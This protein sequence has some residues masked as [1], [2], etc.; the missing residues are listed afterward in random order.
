[1][2]ITINGATNTISSTGTVTLPTVAGVTSLGNTALGDAEASDTHAIKGATTLL[3]N[4]ASA[5]LTVTQTG[6]GNAFVVE[7][8]AS[9]DSTPFVIDSAG[10]VGI[11]LTTI[12]TAKALVATSTSSTSQNEYGV[13]AYN[14][15]SNT[16]GAVNKY[17]LYGIGYADTGYAGSGA[18][19]GVFGQSKQNAAVNV[20]NSLF[21]MQSQVVS[22]FAGTIG[23]A[24]GL[25][26]THSHST[27]AVTDIYGIQIPAIAGSTTTNAY[28]VHINTITGA[29]NNYGFYSNIASAANSYNFYAAGTAANY[30]AGPLYIGQNYYTSSAIALFYN[31]G[32]ASAIAAYNDTA[33]SAATTSSYT[34]NGTFIGTAA[35]SFTLATLNHFSANQSTLGAGSVVTNQRGFQSQAG[36]VGATNNFG[37]SAGNTAAVTAGKVAYGFHSAVNIATG[38]GTTWGFYAAGTAANYFGGNVT[39]GGG[40]TLGYGAGSGGTVTQATSKATAVTLNKP[41]GQITM[42]ADALAAGASVTFIV[43]NSTVTYAD[44]TTVNLVGGV[45][46]SENYRIENENTNTGLFRVR[47]TNL[48]AGSLSESAVLNFCVI[49]GSIT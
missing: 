22:A 19:V 40:G 25:Y 30:L 3:A 28:G 37:F 20:S 11:G 39:V 49:K 10:N 13:Y 38:G 9:T 27:A 4:S 29:T 1:M 36:L 41:S 5:A 33:V 48:S 42:A 6:A 26:I 15:A 34:G 24:V 12:S 35:S 31:S 21:G 44:I 7:D 23:A 2:S 17:G 43:N 46:S 8:S 32:T 16:S 47:V 45:S 18:V 14:L